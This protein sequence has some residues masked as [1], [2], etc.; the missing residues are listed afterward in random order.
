MEFALRELGQHIAFAK[1]LV[2]NTVDFN[3]ASAVFAEDHFVADFY[4]QNSANTAIE[5]LART[6][7]DNLAALWLFLGGI[8]QNDTA[9]GGLFC[10]EWLDNDAVIEW[11]KIYISHLK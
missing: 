11:T 7:R 2:L 4:A 1:D 9:C 5:K 3:F 10:F 8:G 6:D